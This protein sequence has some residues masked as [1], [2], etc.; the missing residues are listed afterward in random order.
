MITQVK[1]YKKLKYILTY[2]ND[3]SDSKKYPVIIFLHG[4]G[5]VGNDIN[6]LME[7]PF[8][9]IIGEYEKFDFITAAPQCNL[10]TWFDMFGDIIGFAE[11]IAGLEFADAERI[12][13]VGASMGGYGVWQLA[14]S[15]PELFAAIVPICGG[16]MYWNASRLKNIPVW[17]FHGDIDKT[18]DKT[19]SVK[20]TEA[21]N[22]AGG[23]ARL[24]I[25]P[26][27]GHDAWS[28][29]YRNPEVFEWLKSQKKTDTAVCENKFEGSKIYG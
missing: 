9:K 13:A 6:K 15:K 21:V 1:N 3:F 5:T 18:V 23:N 22:K 2:P 17:A 26:Q 25:Y 20:M 4:A 10:N 19:E 7:N 11:H 29:T 12:Y 27:C 8:Y 16:G 28:Q 24:T 14:M